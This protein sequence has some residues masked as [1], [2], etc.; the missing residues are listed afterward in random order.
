[1]ISTCH[2]RPAIYSGEPTAERKDCALEPSCL[3]VAACSAHNLML[4]FQT[5]GDFLP[6]L[7]HT[8]DMEQIHLQ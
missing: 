3:H 7:L 4:W 8:T 5:P 6:Q 1:M 2:L